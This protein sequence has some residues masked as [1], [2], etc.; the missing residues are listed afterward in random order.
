LLASR[1]AARQILD[2]VWLGGD[3]DWS[4]RR[5]SLGHQSRWNARRLDVAGREVLLGSRPKPG[6]LRLLPGGLSKPGAYRG[7]SRRWSPRLRTQRLRSSPSL[8]RRPQVP[9]AGLLRQ[10]ELAAGGYASAG[11]VSSYTTA[12]CRQ[13]TCRPF[14]GLTPP[15]RLKSR[16]QPGYGRRTVQRD[17][18]T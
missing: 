12:C 6:F 11:F 18:I 2:R 3:C 8:P 10:P 4:Q 16:S 17:E 13:A 15:R 5:P 1:R 14:V 7:R 9:G